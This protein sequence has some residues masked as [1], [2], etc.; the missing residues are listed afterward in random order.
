MG[1]EDQDARLGSFRRT[2][3]TSKT[4]MGNVQVVVLRDL[5]VQL[6]CKTSIIIYI[7]SLSWLV[8]KSEQENCKFSITSDSWTDFQVGDDSDLAYLAGRLTLSM[9]ITYLPLTNERRF[10]HRR[11]LG[12]NRS[13]QT[14]RCAT[15]HHP[16]GQS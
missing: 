6:S 16:T 2:E 8:L 5:D 11:S 10:A 13:R 4:N 12:E 1:D 3:K 9:Y 15:S 7:P 14:I